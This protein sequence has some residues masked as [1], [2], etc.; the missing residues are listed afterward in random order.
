LPNPCSDGSYVHLP[1][2]PAS[3][4]RDGG[5]LFPQPGVQCLAKAKHEADES[6]CY[7]RGGPRLRRVAPGRPGR[8]RESE[9]Q[10]MRQRGLD[11]TVVAALIVGMVLTNV[12]AGCQQ[13]SAT[14]EP[15]EAVVTGGAGFS[16][17]EPFPQD[18]E[19]VS[20]EE[21]ERRV[22]FRILLPTR[23]SE[24]DTVTRVRLL[25]T[26]TPRHHRP[27]V[28]LF[29]SSGLITRQNW[30]AAPPEAAYFEWLK[31]PRTPTPVPPGFNYKLEP[32][33]AAMASCGSERCLR[34]RT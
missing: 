27:A 18:W 1:R 26:D 31:Q 3:P 12:L 23:L 22:D 11:G 16:V 10:A 25:R 19:W 2:R 17:P 4:L 20:L 29:Y 13:Q 30:A 8:S 6:F 14:V 32:R 5:F 33:C 21:A 9:V 24:G 7:A 15:T 28:W 34:N